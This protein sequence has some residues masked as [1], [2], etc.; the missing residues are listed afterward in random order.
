VPCS[1]RVRVGES[2]EKVGE[3]VPHDIK[4][5]AGLPAAANSVNLP[6]ALHFYKNHLP[7]MQII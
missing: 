3:R 5:V 7:A 6:H 1:V 2:E 4:H